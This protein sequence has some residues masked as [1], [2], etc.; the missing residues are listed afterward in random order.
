MTMS[1]HPI[2]SIL[3]ATDLS[4]ACDPVLRAAGAIAPRTGAALHVIHAFDL[5]PSPQFHTRWNKKSQAV[6]AQTAWGKWAH[7]DSNLGPRDY[8]SPALTAE[9]WA[10]TIDRNEKQ[11]A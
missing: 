2:E 5:P 9:L 6:L 7:Q 10:R 3:A 1:A 8:E 11:L 4:P